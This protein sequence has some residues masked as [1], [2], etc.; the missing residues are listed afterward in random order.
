MIRV[1][2]RFDGN[3]KVINQWKS[4]VKPKQADM[5]VTG[6]SDGPDFMGR[7]YDDAADTFSAPLPPGPPSRAQ[8]IIDETPVGKTLPDIYEACQ[9]ILKLLKG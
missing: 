7:T 8:E 1:W 5:E 3:K 6:R 4:D 9:E 2:V